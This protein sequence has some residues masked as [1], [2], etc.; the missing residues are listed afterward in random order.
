MA[1]SLM[2]N[3]VFAILLAFDEARLTIQ[4]SVSSSF[5]F[6]AK[7]ITANPH[8]WFIFCVHSS[9]VSKAR[10]PNPHA[11][12]NPNWQVETRHVSV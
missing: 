3:I 11:Y 5:R 1:H 2:P 8:V 4:M 10:L 6:N 7:H 9:V 12:I